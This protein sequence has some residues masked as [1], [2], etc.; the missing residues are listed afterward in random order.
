MGI[1]IGKL[2]LYTLCAGIPPETTLPVMLDVGTENQERLADPL[3]L[4]LRQRRVRGADYQAFVDE[5][6]EAVRRVFPD[7]L[8]QW[9]DFLKENAITQLLRFRDRLPSFNDHIQG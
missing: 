7:T 3:Y 9:E 6:V 5:F 8:L 2:R 1:P 4:G